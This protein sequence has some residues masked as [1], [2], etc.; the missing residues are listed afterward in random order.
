MEKDKYKTDVIFRVDTTKDF[1]GDVIAVMP[2]DAEQNGNVGYYVHV[3]QHSTGNYQVILATSR[4]A[5]EKEY[6]D[7]KKEM[8]QGHGY[9]FNV[10]K[11]QNHD[12]FLK[13]YYE[14]IK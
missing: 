9:N 4:L 11:K 5:T 14:A 13:S 1:K 10:I 2:H 6:A 3:G 8:E 7:L 12:K